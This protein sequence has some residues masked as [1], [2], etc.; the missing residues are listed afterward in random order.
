MT[1]EKFE[2]HILF[3]KLNE[4]FKKY[5]MM[6]CIKKQ[7]YLDTLIC[8]FFI[9]T[10]GTGKTLTLKFII[11]RLLRLYNKNISFDLTKTKAF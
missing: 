11:E 7:L 9:R 2:Y 4:F 6:L 3:R 5:L 8:L 1:M 10:V